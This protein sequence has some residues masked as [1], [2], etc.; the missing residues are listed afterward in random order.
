MCVRV[1]VCV[2]SHLFSL[3]SFRSVGRSCLACLVWLVYWDLYI[4]KIFHSLPVLKQSD[5]ETV[6][7]SVCQSS[8]QQLLLMFRC[9]WVFV[10]LSACVCA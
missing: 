3:Y 6:K 4:V 1:C 9:V 10:Y 2:R 8:V 5:S 7:Q